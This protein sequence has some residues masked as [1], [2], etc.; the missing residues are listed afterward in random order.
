MALAEYRAA[1]RRDPD[2]LEA[3]RGMA[4]ILRDKGAEEQALPY[5]RE[6]AERSG[7]G[8]DHARLGWALVRAGRWAEAADAFQEARERGR[9][10]P[11]TVQG[12]ELAAAA[13]RAALGD[14]GVGREASGVRDGPFESQRSTPNAVVDSGWRRAW[15][16]LSNAT[17]L[18]VD[19]VQRV[20][21]VLVGVV[22]A[23]GIALRGWNTLMSRDAPRDEPGVPLQHLRGLIV[24]EMETGRRLGRVRSVLYDPRLARL[25]G[26]Q[27][28]GRWRWRVAPWTAVRGVGAGGLLLSEE[29]ALVGGDQVPDLRGLVRTRPQPLGPG[30]RR[31]RVVTE[32]G[33]VIAFTHPNRLWIDGATGH[34]TFEATPSRFHEAWRVTLTALQLGPVDWLMGRLLDQGLELL[35]GRLSARVRLP[36]SL[37]RSTDRDVVIVSGE[38][39]EWIDQHFQRLEAEAQARLAQVRQGSRVALE[40]SGTL[41]RRGMEKV[42]QARPVLERVRDTGIEKARPVIDRVRTSGA[43]LAR[44]SAE[45]ALGG[46]RK[47]KRSESQNDTTGEL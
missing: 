43:D 10:D 33:A 16:T 25:V 27:T 6:V 36:V 8:V 39:Q 38:A 7:E 21:F 30:R 42:A 1:L 15:G 22:L 2:S 9:D 20:L 31:K 41:A 34:V 29:S 45:G 3:K 32:D 44:R 5:L 11:E 4:R 47:G 17:G 18:I 35:P 26:F 14:G 12:S 23:S 19:T 13:A 40:K 24:R 37:I 28:G 46:S